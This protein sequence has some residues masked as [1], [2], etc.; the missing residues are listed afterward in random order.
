MLYSGLHFGGHRWASAVV[1][2]GGSDRVT[3]LAFLEFAAPLLVAVGR[4][5]HYPS[6]GKR[7]LVTAAVW[8][9]PDADA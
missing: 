3:G 1:F 8:P 6:A 4:Q 7:Q 5:K 2:A 9:A